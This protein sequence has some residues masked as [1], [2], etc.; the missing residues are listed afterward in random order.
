MMQSDGKEFLTT[1]RMA[2]PLGDLILVFDAGGVLA[3]SDYGDHEDRLHR[4]LS[5]RMGRHVLR[6]G[7]VP[8][9][10]Q[11]AITA[12]FSGELTAIDGIPVRLNGTPFQNRAWA[13]LRQIPPGEPATYADQAARI[14]N[15]R[16]ARA[17]GSAN[18]A[19]PYSLIVPCHRVIGASGALTGYAGGLERKRWL[20]DHERRLA[21][22]RSL[23]L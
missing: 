16:A 5:R 20:L 21:R 18:H 8:S 3:G 19:N 4:L 15:P 7:P 2:T 1:G 23:L 10:V 11:A 9:A 14:G 17:V 22:A 6:S 12:Y 13:A